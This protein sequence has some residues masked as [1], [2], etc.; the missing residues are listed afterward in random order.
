MFFAPSSA[1]PAAGTGARAA[2]RAG[3]TGT[4]KI[5]TIKTA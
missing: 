5:T 3:L 1:A 4:T 2:A